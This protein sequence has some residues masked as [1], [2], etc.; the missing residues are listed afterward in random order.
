[1]KWI[2]LKNGNLAFASKSF[3]IA[4]WYIKL[5]NLYICF[6]VRYDIQLNIYVN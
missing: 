6:I 3:F 4:V 2:K 1:M 5:Y